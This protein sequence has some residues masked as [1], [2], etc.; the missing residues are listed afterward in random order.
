MNAVF[1]SGLSILAASLLAAPVF[2]ADEGFC[3]PRVTQ[4]E[5]KFPIVSQLRGQKGTVY[6]NV[7]VDE[8]GR[9]QTAELHRSSGH[10]LLDR[11]ATKSVIG[12]WLFDVSSCARSD[13]PT[14]HLVAVEY[15]NDEY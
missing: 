11:A 3:E 7:R 8:N 14:N 9:A 15:R 1:A 4:S 2:A 6:I 12:E 10:R 13:L 5:T